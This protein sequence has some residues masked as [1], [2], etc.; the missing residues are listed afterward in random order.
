MGRILCIDYGKSRI[1]LA[2]SDPMQI[3][4]SPLKTI[5]S[6]NVEEAILL[7]QKEVIKNE[8]ELIAVGLPI[9][10]SGNS[11]AQTEEVKCFI[12]QLKNGTSVP[13]V[14]VDERL[15]S[16]EAIRTLHKK[17]IKTGHNKGEI[18]KTAAAIIL[19]T[20]LDT[21]NFNPNL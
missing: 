4:A 2:L 7:I 11:T 20:Y 10:L 18:D 5:D 6:H 8:V 19:Q 15:S 13:I 17:G 14:E 12:S 9:A 1:G 16:V 21:K 3:I